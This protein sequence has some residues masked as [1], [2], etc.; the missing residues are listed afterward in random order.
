MFQEDKMDPILFEIGGFKLRYYGLMYALAFFIGIEIAKREAKRV[1]MSPALLENFAITAMVSGLIGGR[2]YYVLFN[3]H[4]YFNNPM[5]I[6]AVWNGGMAIHGGIIGGIIGTFIFAHRNKVSPWKLGDIAAAPFILGQGIGRFG[7]L[8]NGEIH[9]VPT[10]TPWKVIFTLKPGF[11]TW[12]DQY[13][14]MSI[15]AQMKYKELV[16]W[17]IVFPESSPAGSEF[18]NLPLHPA[19]L[20]EMFLNFTAFLLIWFYFRKKEYAAGTVWWIYVIMYS[21]IR[22]FVS[23]FRAEDLMIAGFRAPHAI[24]IIFVSVSIIMIKYLN[25]RDI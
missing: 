21:L 13:R 2:L 14:S 10:F 20:Y 12:Y 22:V 1:N 23:F 7:N 8:M 3:P 24:S 15:E 25:K 9:G 4:Y 16:P 17:G 19:M 11:Y 5:E 18:P 6:L